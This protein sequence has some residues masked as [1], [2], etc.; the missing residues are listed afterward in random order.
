ME[1][2]YMEFLF[3]FLVA[4]SEI[5]KGAILYLKKKSWQ[6]LKNISLFFFPFYLICLLPLLSLFGLN[7]KLTSI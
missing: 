1:S 7:L 3:K 5:G 2:D 4:S 6:S